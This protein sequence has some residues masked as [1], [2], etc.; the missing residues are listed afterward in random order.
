MNEAGV[1]VAGHL[2]GLAR[3][4][5]QVAAEQAEAIARIAALVVATFEN[6]GKLLFCGNGGSAA[7]AQHLATEYIVRFRADRRGLPAIALTTDTSLLTAAAN[8]YGFARVFSRQV[9]ALGARG[10]LLFLHSTSGESANLVEAAV[11]ARARGV[12]TVALLARGGGVLRNVVDHALVL[13][14]DDGAHAQELHLAIGHA[15]CDRVETWL[16]TRTEPQ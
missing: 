10:D 1:A 15:I 14:T 7:D 12:T 8:D 13:P 2:R 9:A 4:A 3:L 6:G 11:E 5:E 16:R